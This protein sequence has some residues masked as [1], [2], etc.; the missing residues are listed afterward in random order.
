MCR[1]RLDLKGYILPQPSIMQQ[2]IVTTKSSIIANSSADSCGIL[3]LLID[4]H[5]CR[6]CGIEM[7]GKNSSES[8]GRAIPSEARPPPVVSSGQP[9]PVRQV[10]VQRPVLRQQA[11]GIRYSVPQAPVSVPLSFPCP[12][13]GKSCFD[14]NIPKR[15]ACACKAVVMRSEN[16]EL[17]Q[18]PG[19]LS[20]ANFLDYFNVRLQ[21]PPEER[22]PQLETVTLG[23]FED[24]LPPRFRQRSEVQ[25]N[26][27][28][29]EVLLPFFLSKSRCVGLNDLLAVQGVRFKVMAAY[30]LY[31]VVGMGTSRRRIFEKRRWQPSPH[32]Q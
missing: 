29:N 17:S 11:N 10:V 19:Q 22:P 27:L 1:V 2:Y 4:S 24:S 28:V 9:A 14:G 26:D 21:Y 3:L 31:G 23:V 32:K 15:L 8:R 20:A 16:G 7:G 6:T 5:A 13:C 30:P 18:F 12:R 25:W